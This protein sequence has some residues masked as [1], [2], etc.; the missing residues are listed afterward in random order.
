[1]D[2]NTREAPQRHLLQSIIARQQQLDRRLDSPA[3]YVDARKKPCAFVSTFGPIDMQTARREGTTGFFG[4]ADLVNP[5]AYLLP[6]TPAKSPNVGL[7]GPFY[8]CSSALYCELSWTYT[9]TPGYNAPI[10]AVPAGN[11]LDPVV[12]QNGGAII[13]NN[14]CNTQQFTGAPVRARVGVELDV[15]DQRRG[16]SFT[17]GRQGPET[18]AGLGY[19]FKKMPAETRLDVGTI[20]EPRLYVTECRMND[21]LDDATPF[22]AASVAAWVTF[23]MKGYQ[24]LP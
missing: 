18:F 16:R 7:H 22:N 1:M 15:F 11:L 12:P 4:A 6:S 8:W 5:G 14:F 10:N 24:V 9:V 19:G 3:A 13:L 17:S 21:T 2:Q 20:I 23:V